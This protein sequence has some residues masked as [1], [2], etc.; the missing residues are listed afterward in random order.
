[1]AGMCLNL[2]AMDME[3][4]L[5]DHPRLL[6]T[7]ERL[8]ELQHGIPG[9]PVLGGY[10]GRLIRRADALLGA[11]PLVYEKPDGFRLLPVSRKLL[12]R[13][14]VLGLAWRLTGNGAYA[15]K[16]VLHLME[17]AAFPDWNP[18]HFLDVAEMAAGVGLGL[19]WLHARLTAGQRETL[20]AALHA[21]AIVP[22]LA[23][24][25]AA[26]VGAVRG[27]IHWVDTDTNW[28]LVCNG[29]IL[30]AALA[31]TDPSHRPDRQLLSTIIATVKQQYP[32]ALEVY[33]PDGAYPEGPM[34]WGYGTFYAVLA[35]DALQSAMGDASLLESFPE[36]PG[37][38][39]YVLYA[40]GPRD[41]PLSY[42]DSSFSRNAGRH[43]T[44]RLF[45]ARKFGNSRLARLHNRVLQLEENRGRISAFDLIWYASGEAD[46][47]A[48]PLPL[49]R[50]FA[51]A[52]PLMIWRS[53]WDDPDALFVG[54]VAGG[55]PGPHGHLDLGSFEFR[56]D[57][58][59][60]VID[61]GRD[62][63]S[64]PG[65]WEDHA[66][67]R[68]WEYFRLGTQ[69]HNVPMLDGRQQVTPCR[70]AFTDWGSPDK[71]GARLDLSP[72]YAGARVERALQ[73]LD[74]RGRLVVE[75]RIKAP[76]G[77]R[78]AWGLTV[79]GE[80][81]VS[82]DGH[83]VTLNRNGKTLSIRALAPAAAAWR[84]LPVSLPSP[85]HTPLPADCHRLILD[86]RLDSPDTLIT[87][88]FLP[89][90]SR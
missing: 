24:H 78:V 18:V 73:L 31:L 82:D 23:A 51:G 64:L 1:M 83:T 72:A 20:K 55:D 66:G 88:S 16:A 80:P 14:T 33:Q 5:R 90:S 89:G 15:D 85:P 65:Y 29:G 59:A 76:I 19:D 40:H 37:T 9:D 58:E 54:V 11:D 84:I 38:G 12:D 21:K 32:L 68:R 8:D 63:Y 57:G 53:A 71:P 46:A 67:G 87:V 13:V 48:A 56:A 70:V 81:T 26:R 28:N 75:D 7:T 62:D 77:T 36:L 45:L 60:W 86:Y 39:A 4:Q 30:I 47:L 41:F 79:L 74:G 25:V 6:L 17:V 27:P 43:G 42:A 69:G 49:D 10:C 2:P 22:Y 44:A 35:M 34:Y 50:Y 52:T 3:K 61:P